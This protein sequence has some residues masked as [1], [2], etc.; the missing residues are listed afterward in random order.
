MELYFYEE[1]EIDQGNIVG[2]AAAR[3]V[4]DYE[5]Q[6]EEW[7]KDMEREHK[8]IKSAYLPSRN[9]TWIRGE[10][11]FFSEKLPVPDAADVAD[12]FKKIFEGLE[13]RTVLVAAHSQYSDETIEKYQSGEDIEARPERVCAVFAFSENGFGF[14]E[15][16]VA[17][18]AEGQ[19]YIDTERSSRET[20]KRILSRIVDHAIIDGET[21]PERHKKYNA[22]M[23][24]TCSHACAICYPKEKTE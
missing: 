18:D 10:D 1:I 11:G 9:R 15:I 14:G 21:D 24:S 19:M 12:A 8:R 17:C 3:V 5:Y 23:K 7:V 22:F 16:T 6:A 4:V 20:V 13:D 2:S